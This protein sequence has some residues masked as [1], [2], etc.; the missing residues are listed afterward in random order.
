MA[1]YTL[2]SLLHNPMFLAPAL[3][4]CCAQLLKVLIYVGVNHTFSA[5]RI[6]GAGGMPSSHS[7]TVCALCTAAACRYG[8]GSAEFPIT[9]FFAFIVMYDAMGVRW[10]TGMQA[11]ILNEMR[12]QFANLGKVFS[13]QKELKEF[14][15]HTP[16]QVVCGMAVGI[17]IGLITCRFIL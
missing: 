14:V 11:K 1:E 8:F 3:A 12:R 7:S 2:S 6:F 17:A 13:D 15:G 4:W 16:L 9:F 10:E 5:E